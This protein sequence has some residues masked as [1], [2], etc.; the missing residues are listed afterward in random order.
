M[1]KLEMHEL[2]RLDPAQ[3]QQAARHPFVFV[4]D[5][6]RSMHNVGSIFRTAD[7]FAAQAMHLCGITGTPPHRE[8]AKTALGADETVP[9]QHW[10]SVADCLAELK[11]QGFLII[12]VEQ[13]TESQPLHQ[14][15]TSGQ[16]VALVLG[17]E[18]DGVSQAAL[19]LAD[20]AV[21][22]P[23]FGSKHSLNVS[24]AAGIT[25]WEIVRH[26]L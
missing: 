25:A 18:V 24:V 4:L 23:Q 26:R 15:T 1:R 22:I 7:A 16:P 14:L 9:W 8:I 6:V 5:N 17:N 20:A 13:V 10:P 19:D 12:A 3:A 2:N 11:Q 21:E